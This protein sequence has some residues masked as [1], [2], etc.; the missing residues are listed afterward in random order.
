MGGQRS[1]VRADRVLEEVARASK[2]LSLSGIARLVDAP[3]SSTSDLLDDMVSCGY[4]V[5]SDRRYRL[6]PR[7]MTLRLIAAHADAP[8]IDSD[9]LAALAEYTG[10]PVALAVL[11][12]SDV[13]YL[14]SVGEVSEY[15]EAV[16]GEYRPRPLLR[17][18]AGRAF[19]AFADD[20]ERDRLL[21][22]HAG[23]ADAVGFRREV[24]G[25]R[26]RGHAISDGLADPEIRAAGVPVFERGLLVGVVVVVGRRTRTGRAVDK[27]ARRAREWLD[28]GVAG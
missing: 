2:P 25:I 17:T 12:G 28:G 11:V 15:A 8:P 19:L 18:A 4:L 23:P 9:G 20:G 6:G 1:V 5:R 3:V 13:V 24:A 16:V 22:I 14:G 26:R 10:V 7:L 27:A 21:A